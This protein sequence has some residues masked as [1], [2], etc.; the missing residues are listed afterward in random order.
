MFAKRKMIHDVGFCDIRQWKTLEAL[1]PH[2]ITRKLADMH[3]ERRY[4]NVLSRSLVN[5]LII[6]HDY[7][8]I[9]KSDIAVVSQNVTSGKTGVSALLANIDSW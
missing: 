6:I 7:L 3:I 5:M 1:H 9:E 8:S 4:Q 2:I